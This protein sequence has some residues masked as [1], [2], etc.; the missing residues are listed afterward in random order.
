MADYGRMQEAGVGGS[1]E[2]KQ[3]EYPRLAVETF[4]RAER[5]SKASRQG[6]L[7]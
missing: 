2:G 1:V 5:K 4:K 6:E 3:P 7:F